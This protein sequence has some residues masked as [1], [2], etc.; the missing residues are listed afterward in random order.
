MQQPRSP[1]RKH[2]WSRFK[3]EPVEYGSSEY[4]YQGKALL[5]ARICQLVIPGQP[6]E[7]PD[8]MRHKSFAS[9][10]VY[11]IGF[12]ILESGENKGRWPRLYL[13]VADRR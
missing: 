7:P 3:I 11:F 5:T 4:R 10:A 6:T 8:F 9:V 1:Q 13:S 2:T 12:A